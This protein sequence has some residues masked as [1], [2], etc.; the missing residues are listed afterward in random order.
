LH[1]EIG[2][3]I[4]GRKPG[5]ENS[6]EVTIFDTSGVAIQDLATAGLAVRRAKEKGIGVRV[7]IQK[8]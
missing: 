1:G 4:T 2:E 5:R 7:N 6:L 8:I 3:L